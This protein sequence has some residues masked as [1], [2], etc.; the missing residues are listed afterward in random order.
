[1]INSYY[2]QMLRLKELYLSVYGVSANQY[3]ATKG[4]YDRGYRMPSICAISC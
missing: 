1:M 4:A 3:E 2:H